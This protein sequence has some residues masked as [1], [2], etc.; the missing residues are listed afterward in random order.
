[1]LFF[2]AFDKLTVDQESKNLFEDVEVL[3]V[4]A[5][6]STKNLYICIKSN[7]LIFHENIT[8]MEDL[9]NRQVFSSIASKAFLKPQFELS[10]QYNFDNLYPIY[11]ESLMEEL[12]DKS[13]ISY[14]ILSNAK[15]DIEAMTLK[16]NT[17]E[18][19]ITEGK[20]IKLKDF[21]ETIFQERFS[22]NVLVTFNYTKP[23][24][25]KKVKASI[26]NRVKLSSAHDN[27]EKKSSNIENS[28]VSM[29]NPKKSVY[30]KAKKSYRKSPKDPN[31]IYGRS[32]EG[33]SMPICDILA[34]I[35]EVIIRGKLVNPETRP[36]RNEKTILS[37]VL[38][39]FTDSIK[40][41]IFLKNDEV[42]DVTDEL[43]AGNFYL[44]KGIAQMDTFDRDITIG[45]VVGIKK[46]LDFTS[47]R[48]DDAPV[49]RVELHAHTQ[50]SDMDSV[51]D[52]K[53]MVKRAMDWGHKAIAI[54]DH[55]VVQ[56]FPDANHA[57]S[58][59]NFSS[60]E[61]KQKAKDFK[62]IYGMEAYLVD[63]VQEIVVGGK[64]QSLM[65]SFVVFDIET[66]GFSAINDRIIEIGA[67]KILG[68]EIIDR[69]STFVNPQLPIP[70]EIEQLTGIRDDMVIDAPLIETILP[71]FLD[72]CDGCGLVAHNASFDVGFINHNANKQ[73]ISTDFTVIDTVSL[74]RLL[75]PELSRYR[76]NNVA[77]ALKVSLEN[78]H[79]AVD[80][81]EATA[82]IFIK[83]CDMLKEKGISNVDEID[84]LGEL[85]NQAISK[86]PAYHAI[87]LCTNDIGRIN[88]YKM[89][90]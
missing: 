24:E 83:L 14:N 10:A 84:T 64:G 21:I 33:N 73:G 40:V 85:S 77:K 60:E 78:H 30:E 75:L 47:S 50:M 12:K 53:K 44:L 45:S 87:M 86:L 48:R 79:R 36:I 4:I 51:V 88:L 66:T 57:I 58:P 70:Y 13:V 25:Q 54:T 3:K 7:H 18:S 52:V 68:G 80:D 35:G 22:Y 31:T 74:S 43:K 2:E 49:K 5:S 89:V 6:K 67:V 1:M 81:A 56:S 15:V 61:D 82:E 8:K 42:E 71:E 41:K 62:V 9:L 34:E 26:P 90:S 17:T 23:K 59:W 63:D 65:D 39:D 46:I 32:F 29:A 37:F 11:K 72:F 55:G 28:T 38:T 20:S 76:L 16:I 27:G 69:Y 19:C